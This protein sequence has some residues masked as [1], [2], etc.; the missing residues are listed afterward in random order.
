[1][2][3]MSPMWWTS[4]MLMFILMLMIMMM[5]IYFNLNI[6]MNKKIMISSKKINWQW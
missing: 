4:L 5:M 6:K 3:Q 1:M 2:P